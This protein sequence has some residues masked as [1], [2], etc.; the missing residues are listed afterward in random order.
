MGLET[1]NQKFTNVTVF[2][3]PLIPRTGHFIKSSAKSLKYEIAGVAT[4]PIRIQESGIR[5]ADSRI[6]EVDA[7]TNAIKHVA[8]ALLMDGVNRTSPGLGSPKSARCGK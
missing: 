5:P 3:S 7:R 2:V 6:S 8:S 1:A 4:K